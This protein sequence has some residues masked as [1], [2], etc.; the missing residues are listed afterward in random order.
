M[1]SPYSSHDL[2]RLYEAAGTLPGEVAGI[3]APLWWRTFLLVTRDTGMRVAEV[4]S[5]D[6]GEL[7]L[8]AGRVVLRAEAS[9][10]P[11]LGD[12][13]FELRPETVAML[14]RI[15]AAGYLRISV[16]GIGPFA[17]EWASILQQQFSTLLKLA[18]LADSPLRSLSTAVRSAACS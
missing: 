8:P 9:K 2:A 5:L 14:A 15:K 10:F 3:E 6:T 18:G 1:D 17:A 12:S 16:F 7:D 13:T 11:G 4:L